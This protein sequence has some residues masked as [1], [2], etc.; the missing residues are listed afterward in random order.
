M[1][2]SQ[3]K[4]YCVVEAHDENAR[5]MSLTVNVGHKYDLFCVNNTKTD[6]VISTKTRT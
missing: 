3:Y 4:S 2:I 6:K 5:N 1:K